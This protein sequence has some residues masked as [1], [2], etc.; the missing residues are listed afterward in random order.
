MY[1]LHTYICMCVR[2][3]ACVCVHAREGERVYGNSE[4]PKL[5]ICCIYITF[6]ISTF[7]YILYIHM[8]VCVRVC[9]CECMR[10]RESE[11]VYSSSE[12]LE[13]IVCDICNKFQTHIKFRTH[14]IHSYV[15]VRMCVRV[16]VYVP[17]CVSIYVREIVLIQRF[18]S[19]QIDY[20]S[21]IKYIPIRACACICTHFY[22]VCVC[23]MLQGGENPHDA[24]SCRSFFAKE[25]L[26]IELFR[27]K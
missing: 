25:P 9:A 11:R 1:I 20:I 3:R 10:A 7:I 4:V 19:P 14:I 5:N 13:S 26:I 12:V 8:C 23:I 2:V 16:Y 27:G 21:Y 24:L 15:C 18:L 6:P 17:M 22:T